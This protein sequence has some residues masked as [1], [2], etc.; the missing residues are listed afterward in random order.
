MNRRPRPSAARSGR[1]AASSRRTGRAASGRSAAERSAPGRAA[2]T[3]RTTPAELPVL[4]VGFIPGVEPD[5]FARRWRSGQRPARL[6][7]VPVPHSRQ[8][9]VLRAGEVDMCFVRLPLEADGEDTAGGPGELHL[10]E[11]WQ[12]RPMVVVGSENILS[13][14]EELTVADLAEDP[15][16]PSAHPDD[17][18]DRVAVVATGVGHALLPMS[19]ARLHHRKDVV[20][21]PLADAPATRIALAW[22][23]AAD[24]AVRQEFVGAVRGRTARSSR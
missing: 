8:A 17:A 22:P 18:A 5:R 1:T 15:E 7:L 11:L 16:I 20:H 21:R 14:H 2:T 23:R 3:E 12:E 19:L 6:E 10:V 9:D 13:L 4:R 24:D